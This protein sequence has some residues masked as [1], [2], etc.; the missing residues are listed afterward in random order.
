[1]RYFVRLIML[2]AIMLTLAGCSKETN[3]DVIEGQVLPYKAMYDP[4]PFGIAGNINNQ[5]TGY[6]ML[7]ADGSKL[8]LPSIE[9]FD[10]LYKEG[11]I[12]DIVLEYR[13]Y[14]GKNAT[15]IGEQESAKLIKIINSNEATDYE[16]RDFTIAPALQKQ[17]DGSEA[18]VM[19][20]IAT[21]HTTLLNASKL[22]WF[23][24][25]Y[26]DGTNYTVRV[27]CHPKLP[28][29]IPSTIGNEYQVYALKILKQEP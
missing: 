1:M 25:Y 20:D 24:G 4:A 6:V 23:I 11:N 14:N 3:A 10:N 8:L 28:T 12:Y 5:L 18:Y 21:G 13:R 22:L 7:L 15:V 27:C 17:N 26:K 29:P 16:M 9:G 19:T 2:A